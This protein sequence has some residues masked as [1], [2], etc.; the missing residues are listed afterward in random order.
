M[1]MSLKKTLERLLAMMQNPLVKTLSYS[2]TTTWSVA[3]TVTITE[4]GL[5]LFRAKYANTP[6]KGLA[7]SL[8]GQNSPVVI[9]SEPNTASGELYGMAMLQATTYNVWAF[10]AAAGRSNA[11]DIHRIP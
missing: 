8:S 3:G 10:C 4:A 7:L 11:I 6:V 2:S 9:L 5:Y 1:K